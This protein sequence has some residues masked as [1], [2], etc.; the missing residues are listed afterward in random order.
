M[1]M[2]LPPMA[3]GIVAEYGKAVATGVAEGEGAYG[4]KLKKKLQEMLGVVR[5]V[6]SFLKYYRGK[7]LAFAVK[8]TENV[9]F[10]PK[11]IRMFALQ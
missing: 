3:K 8:L 4:F 6:W 9:A 7:T 1:K 2:N 10:I 11:R 5:C